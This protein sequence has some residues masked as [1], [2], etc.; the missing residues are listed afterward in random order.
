MVKDQSNTIM[1]NQS[2][3]ETTETQ[4]K[5][6]EVQTKRGWVQLADGDAERAD[7]LGA[8]LE[9]RLGGIWKRPAV[10]SKALDALTEQM[11]EGV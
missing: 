4:I 7:A 5:G 8:T 3:L 11:G 10:L 1:S 9:S 6:T 2:E